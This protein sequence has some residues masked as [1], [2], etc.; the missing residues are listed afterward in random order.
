MEAIFEEYGLSVIL[1]LM[2]MG[3][4]VTMSYLLGFIEM[5]C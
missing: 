1:I 4:I 5:Y 3:F 2:G